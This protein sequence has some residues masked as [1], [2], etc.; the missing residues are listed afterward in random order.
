MAWSSDGQRV[1]CCN[2]GSSSQLN[3]IDVGKDGSSW[4]LKSSWTQAA[5]AESTIEMAEFLPDKKIVAIEQKEGVGTSLLLF[6]ADG[7]LVKKVDLNVSNTK[8]NG[9]VPNP[10][11]ITPCK[12][13]LV[14]AVFDGGVVCV[15]Q[16]ED[17]KLHSQFKPVSAYLVVMD[18]AD[19]EVESSEWGLCALRH[20]IQIS[21]EAIL[22][23]HPARSTE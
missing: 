19:G 22:A 4:T 20:D 21:M 17:L 5:A 15:V 18:K 9:T 7:E 8:S 11:M 16:A 13:G 1:L 6:S 14:A 3:V 12:D 2:S 10:M 23:C